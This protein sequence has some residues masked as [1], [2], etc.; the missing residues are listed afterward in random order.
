[1]NLRRF[2]AVVGVDSLRLMAKPIPDFDRMTGTSKVLALIRRGGKKSSREVVELAELI[3]MVKQ[4][5]VV[6][7]G[8]RAEI[9]FAAVAQPIVLRPMSGCAVAGKIDG[10]IA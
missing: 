6:R 9:K 3:P 5:C 7:R 2:T 10:P 1:M 8:R 4:A